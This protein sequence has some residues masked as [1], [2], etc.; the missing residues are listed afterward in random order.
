[1]VCYAVPADFR[2][3]LKLVLTKGY[4]TLL[5]VLEPEPHHQIQSSIIP[6]T[7]SRKD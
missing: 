2:V 1:M 6:R 7:Y 3:D 5:R 4:F